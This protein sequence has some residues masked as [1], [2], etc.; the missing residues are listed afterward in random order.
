VD[1]ETIVINETIDH[2]KDDL[3]IINVKIIVVIVPKDLKET[4]QEIVSS[5]KAKMARSE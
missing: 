5:E 1:Q 3:T 2:I 4:D